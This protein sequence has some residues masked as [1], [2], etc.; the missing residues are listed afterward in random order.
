MTFSA[1]VCGHTENTLLFPSRLEMFSFAL[2]VVEK[3]SSRQKKITSSR[4]REMK[5]ILRFSRRKYFPLSAT[6]F[7]FV[8]FGC[9]NAHRL[10]FIHVP[11]TFRQRREGSLSID[12]L[13]RQAQRSLIDRWARWPTKIGVKFRRR[14]SRSLYEFDD[15]EFLRTDYLHSSPICEG[16][17]RFWKMLKRSDRIEWKREWESQSL[18]LECLFLNVF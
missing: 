14:T 12:L 6:L 11:P 13:A 9:K 2:V 3:I 15:D 1:R 18:I 10:V 8:C 16:E 5:I 4:E 17:R 7:F